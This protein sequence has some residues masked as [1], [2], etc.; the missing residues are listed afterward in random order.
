MDYRKL[1]PKAI[2]WSGPMDGERPTIAVLTYDIS[3][4]TSLAEW[5][6]LTDVATERD[7]NLVCFPGQA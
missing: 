5:Q 4:E 2:E 6:C 1:R 3:R 7:I